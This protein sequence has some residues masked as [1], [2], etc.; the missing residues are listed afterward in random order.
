VARVKIGTFKNLLLAKENLPTLSHAVRTAAAAVTSLLVTRLLGLPEPYWA[1][2]T[3][4]IVMQSTL[5]AAL[6]VSVQ[7]VVGTAIGAAVGALAATRFS[8]NAFVFG[9]AVFLIG[10]LCVA[11]RVDRSAYR[12]ASIALAIVMLI[13]RP[14]NPWMV[15]LHRF[16]EVSL[17][18][19]VALALTAAWP[20]RRGGSTP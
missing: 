16:I 19:V 9:I 15:G 4:L 13:M 7:R 18:V 6:T 1:A 3:S 17:G 10:W 2:I 20:E 11:L 14:E 5:G 12:Y 8:G